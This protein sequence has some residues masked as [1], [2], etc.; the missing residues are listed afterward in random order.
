MIPAINSISRKAAY[1][2]FANGTLEIA[3]FQRPNAKS[4][5][6]YKSMAHDLV[7]SHYM[8]EVS[9]YKQ[10]NKKI[11]FDG[12]HRMRGL[13]KFMENKLPALFII[14][15]SNG[16][17]NLVVQVWYSAIG[18]GVTTGEDTGRGNVFQ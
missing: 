15:D 8:G 3:D 5:A 6:Q 16:Q 10:D 2:E 18:G 7:L 4:R 12:G 11:L 14:E 9:I 13:I 1:T 17:P